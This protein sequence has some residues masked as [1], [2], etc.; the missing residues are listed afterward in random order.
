LIYY[1]VNPQY[2]QHE[3]LA[4]WP[5]YPDSDIAIR[6]VPIRPDTSGSAPEPASS[7][8]ETEAT[9]AATASIHYIMSSMGAQMGIGKGYMVLESE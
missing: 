2:R 6:D 9:D 1:H 7:V 3:D 4:A 5:E 8:A